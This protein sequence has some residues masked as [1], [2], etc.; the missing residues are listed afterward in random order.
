[1]PHDVS[2]ET[3]DWSALDRMRGGFLS[4]GSPN[5]RGWTSISDVANYDFTF[6]QRI[7]WK[8]DAVLAELAARGWT[9]PS[10]EILDWGCGSGVA[11]RRVI[12]WLGPG[13]FKRADLFDRSPLALEFAVR[14]TRELLPDA[15]V[16][17]LRSD[18]A[19]SGNS[20]G[21][22]VISHVLNELDPPSRSRL[23]DLARRAGA[24]LWV[25]PGSRAESRDLSAMRDELRNDFT[26]VAPCPH[27]SAC[28]MLAPENEPHWCHFRAPVPKGVLA[29]GGWVRFGQQAGIDLR[30]LPYSFL[31]LERTGVRETTPG[32]PASGCA[33]V[34]A[35]CRFYK[36]YARLITCRAGGVEDLELQKRTAPRHFKALNRGESGLFWRIEAA[37]KRILSIDALAPR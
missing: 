32:L 21:L 27:Q 26:V 23:L 8:W 34:L 13:L 31:V 22:L 35:G 1:M 20:I 9:P 17:A 30:S 15:E 6:A 14:R 16:C 10:G 19:T 7:G 3:L 2:W 24:V 25:E 11:A 29:H 18:P 12:E 5:G 36:G 28:G 4:P 33:R 37:D